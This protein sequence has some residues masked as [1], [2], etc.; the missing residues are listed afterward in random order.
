MLKE[1]P[2]H[3]SQSGY[4]LPEV[5][6]TLATIFMA[7][8]V[9]FGSLLTLQVQSAASKH[10]SEV[11]NDVKSLTEQMMAQPM[12]GLGAQFP[13]NTDIPEFNDLH[14]PSERVRVVYADGDPNAVPLEYRVE[15]SWKTTGGRP[16]KLVVHGMRV[17]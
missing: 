16:A 6:L 11:L 5:M 9:L 10:K 17:R 12:S 4:M 3:Q 8:L 15:A 14:A 13:H 7:T 2:T 1:N